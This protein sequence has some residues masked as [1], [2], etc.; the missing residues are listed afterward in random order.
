MGRS[1][2]F[3]T[4]WYRLK[5]RKGAQTVF[6]RECDVPYALMKKVDAEI[7]TLEAEGVLINVET[8]DWGSP[9]VVIPKADGG[10]CLCIDYKADVNERLQDAHYPIRKID[11][12]LNSLQN[13]CFFCP[14]GLFKAYLHV[15]FDE[16][17]SEIQTISSNHWSYRLHRLFFRIKTALSEFNKIIDQILEEFQHNL[18]ACLDQLQKFYLH[19]NQQKC[20]LIQRANQ[21]LGPFNKISKSSGKVTAIVDRPRPN[22]TEDVRTFLGIVTYYSRFIHG[23]ST[24]TTLL[25]HILCANTIFKRT[26]ACEVAFLKLKQTIASDQLAFDESP[27][28]IDD[29]LSHIVDGHEHPIAFTSRSLTAAAQNYSQLDREVL[30]IVFTVDHFFQYLFGRHFKL[31][32]ENQPLT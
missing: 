21:I 15:P 30:A 6:H 22:S 27:T 14:L 23:T 28:G 10:V 20:P 5:F 25:R 11:D 26:S 4:S 31:V 3:L 1:E 2:K 9:L 29:V 8:S 16:Q 17:S 13:S 32:T 18:I 24:I 12:T 7:D 19:L